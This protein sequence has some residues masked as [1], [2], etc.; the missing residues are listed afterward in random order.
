ME[1]IHNAISYC[2]PV[3][4]M[5]LIHIKSVQVNQKAQIQNKHVLITPYYDSLLIVDIKQYKNRMR[6]VFVKLLDFVSLISV[7]DSSWLWSEFI[8][9]F[10]AATVRCE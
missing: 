6:E 5:A 4:M 3:L 1:K 8:G 2:H 10:G 7:T 9:M